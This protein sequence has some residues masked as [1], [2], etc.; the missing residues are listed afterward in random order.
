MLVSLFLQDI[1]CSPTTPTNRSRNH[2]PATKLPSREN[3]SRLALM[4]CR[5]A[6]TEVIESTH[7]NHRLRCSRLLSTSA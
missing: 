1:S 4:K 3:P 7:G 6:P 5:S 2:I